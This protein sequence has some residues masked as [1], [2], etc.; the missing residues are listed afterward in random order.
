MSPMSDAKHTLK[1]T[2]ALEAGLQF[3]AKQGEHQWLIDGDNEEAPTPMAL[4]ASALCGCMSIDVAHILRKG[5]H[6][7]EALKVTFTGQRAE[8]EPKRF[9]RIH[10]QIAV[11]TNAP[12]DAVERAVDLSHQTYC[13][14]WHS[15]RQDIELVTAVELEAI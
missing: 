10:L 1:L 2:L 7:V 9:T 11:K 14:V 3:T 4:L 13:S 8:T 15:L 6:K 12:L 5:R